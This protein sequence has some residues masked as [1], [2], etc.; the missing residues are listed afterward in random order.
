M[1]AAQGPQRGD[2]RLRPGK[3]A[4]TSPSACGSTPAR[5]RSACQRQKGRRAPAR[6]P[7]GRDDGG[8]SSSTTSSRG[9]ALLQLRP[10]QEGMRPRHRRLPTPT[11]ASRRRST[12]RRHEGDRLQAAT[13]AGLS[14]RQ[15]T[16][17]ASPRRSRDPRRRRRSASTASRRTTSNG[18]ITER[19]RYNQ[20]ARHLEPLQRGAH[21]G[22][23][24]DAQA[25][26]PRPRRAP[27]L[28]HREGRG[29]LPQP[30]LPDGDSGARGNIDQM[31][32]LAGM[33]GLMA[34]PSGE[35][36]ETPIRANFREGLNVLEY[37]SSTHGARKG[38]A[39]TALKTADSGYLTRKLCDVAQ[40]VIV[41]RTTAARAAA[42]PSGR[43]TRAS[44]STS[45]RRADHGPPARTRSSTRSPTRS[46]SPRRTD[47][48]R[49][50]ARRSRS[51]ASTSVMVRSPLTCE[52]L[53]RLRS[54][55]YGMDLSTGRSSRRGM[56]VGIIAAQ[57]IGEPGTQLTMRTFHTAASARVRSPRPSTAPNGGTGR[58]SATATRCR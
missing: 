15:V 52:S 50:A 35:I 43:S 57:S 10:R 33:R 48:H 29:H 26:P 16:T 34:K 14:L 5:A 27:R 40:N 19:E 36:I 9:H 25:R 18:I 44:R 23:G 28:G 24:R 8:R 4:S 53:G 51:S 46:S 41:T 42:S 7:P 49:E 1:R 32:Q 22:P 21:Q 20:L 55:C 30:R 31:K 6:E 11:A 17:S 2:P 12:A 13:V 54:S 45:A 39:D 58:A 56:A 37:F 38:L 47:D 3:I